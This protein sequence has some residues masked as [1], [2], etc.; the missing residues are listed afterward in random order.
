MNL[1]EW[2][3]QEE[4]D[5]WHNALCKQLGYPIPS[6]NQLTGEVDLDAQTTN[7]YTNCIEVD[8]KIIAKV[9]EQYADGLTLTELKPPLPPFLQ[10]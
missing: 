4:F 1:Y 2:N 10:K 7:T 9:E 5:T 3:T 8:G 6:I